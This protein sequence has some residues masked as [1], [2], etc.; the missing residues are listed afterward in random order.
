MDSP[1]NYDFA[2]VK[3]SDAYERGGKPYKRP[4]G[5]Y[6]IALKVRGK[7]SDPKW[8]GGYGTGSRHG[9]ADG[10]WPVSY[11]GTNWIAAEGIAKKVT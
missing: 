11:H 7:Y 3:D 4:C 1:L 8:L 6:R 10:E 9:S 2:N 5:W